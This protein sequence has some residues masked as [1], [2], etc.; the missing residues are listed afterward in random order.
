MPSELGKIAILRKH[1]LFCDLPDAAVQQLAAHA[2]ILA[3]RAGDPIFCKGE[4]GHGL[5]AVLSGF[6]RISAPSGDGRE[7]VLNL[8]GENEIFGEIALLDGGPRTANANALTDCSLM[9]LDHR[10][11]VQLLMREPIVAIRVLEVVC[12]R[13]R[14]TSKHVEELKFGELRMLLAKAL[15]SV[16]EVQGTSAMAEPRLRI[17]QKGLVGH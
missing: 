4:E 14:R 2:R 9:S 11:F 7:I 6:V 12:K 1:D 3:Y 10:D 17:T 5:L 15:L 13:L 16:A 8:I